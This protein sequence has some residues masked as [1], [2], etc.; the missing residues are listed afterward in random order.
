MK[1]TKKVR[2]ANS[3]CKVIDLPAVLQYNAE[4]GFHQA[5]K[6]QDQLL[7]AYEEAKKTVIRLA[8]AFD[9]P[10]AAQDKRCNQKNQQALADALDRMKASYSLI[11]SLMQQCCGIFASSTN[12]KFTDRDKAVKYCNNIAKNF[13]SRNLR[14]SNKEKNSGMYY[15]IRLF[16]AERLQT[17]YRMYALSC[18]HLGNMLHVRDQEPDTAKDLFQQVYDHF[19][20]GKISAEDSQFHAEFLISL[21]RYKYAYPVRNGM[22]TLSEDPTTSE[23]RQWYREALQACESSVIQIKA[24]WALAE[25]ARIEADSSTGSLVRKEKTTEALDLLHWAYS[26]SSMNNYL[27]DTKLMNNIAIVENFS[28]ID[29]RIDWLHQALEGN[30]PKHILRPIETKLRSLS[31]GSKVRS[32]NNSRGYRE[33][34]VNT[35][36]E[37]INKLANTDDSIRSKRALIA[38]DSNMQQMYDNYIHSEKKYILDR[39]NALYVKYD[40]IS[41]LSSRFNTIVSTLSQGDNLE[42]EIS[43]CYDMQIY[44]QY[45]GMSEQKK[46]ITDHLNCIKLAQKLVQVRSQFSD[47]VR[48]NDFY[49]K[50]LNILARMQAIVN[51][52]LM[53]DLHELNL[54]AEYNAMGKVVFEYYLAH[55]NN[56][57]DAD[58]SISGRAAFFCIAKLL[59]LDE[60]YST[61]TLWPVLCDERVQLIDRYEQ[62]KRS[63]GHDSSYDYVLAQMLIDQELSEYDLAVDYD[64]KRKGACLQKAYKLSQ[65]YDNYQLDVIKTKL[66]EFNKE[67]ELFDSFQNNVSLLVYKF[68]ADPQSNLDNIRMYMNNDMVNSVVKDIF[69]GLYKSQIIRAMEQEFIS[70]S[71]IDIEFNAISSASTHQ[72]D[73][74]E[75]ELNNT[76]VTK[77]IEGATGIPSAQ[78]LFSQDS[79]VQRAATPTSQLG[80]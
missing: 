36:Y 17:F 65:G 11:E 50:S 27:L 49:Y 41:P 14:G 60:Y 42:T 15:F 7:N 61:S 21:G 55:A 71:G 13:L 23:S 63:Q 6:Q 22:L 53:C 40:L 73:D 29:D 57:L 12:I 10:E 43:E 2:N 37:A 62:Y 3:N 70:A 54:V 72:V 67:S 58:S 24:Y 5:L 39:Y 56:K 25:L 26:L 76:D 47:V 51:D 32:I 38:C 34:D 18:L 69:A 74:T 30:V 48:D 19:Q 8:P 52:D 78:S 64:V 77:A 31:S 80:M 20:T 68:M 66:E 45:L 79:D 9:K 4:L 59:Y 46:T 16:N 1:Q 28:E 44:V 35:V 75:F 33:S